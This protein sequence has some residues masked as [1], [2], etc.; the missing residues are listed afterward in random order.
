MSGSDDPIGALLQATGRRPA[1]PREREARLREAARA[2][3]QAVLARRRR[4]TMVWALSA[5]AVV[6]LA[7]LGLRELRAPAPSVPLAL[8]LEKVA[9]T[10][11]IESAGSREPLDARSTLA[12]GCTL[13]TEARGG[14]SLRDAAGRSVRLDRE[15]ALGVTDAASYALKRGAIYVDSGGA[16]PAAAPPIRIETPHGTLEDVGTQFQA[17][18]DGGRLLVRVREGQVRLRG[19]HRPA[20]AAA[21]RVIVADGTKVL[22]ADDP[23]GSEGWD[24]A[25]AAVPMMAIEGRPL[26]DFLAWAARERGVRVRYA[27]PDLS[28]KAPSIVLR[29]SVEGMTLDQAVA[30]VMAT[31]GL[32]Y[33]WEAGELVVG[34]AP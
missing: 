10:A 4:L 31:S 19:R 29:G 1:I 2:E 12:A 22:V 24:W 25:E 11:W 26:A 27:G 8:T 6:A 34:E 15:T 32:T 13:L 5:A 17:R 28:R 3:W 14:V 7:V 23:Q 33:R 16:P 21:G 30:S 9:G 20:T 18:L